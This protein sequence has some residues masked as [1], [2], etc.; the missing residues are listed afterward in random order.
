ME[1][2][3]TEWWTD[4]QKST[5]RDKRPKK[6][7]KWTVIKTSDQ[8]ATDAICSLSA[9]SDSQQ[10]QAQRCRRMIWCFL[11]R[12]RLCCEQSCELE[13][14]WDSSSWTAKNA[15]LAPPEITLKA[16]K[17]IEGFCAGTTPADALSSS[18]AVQTKRERLGSGY[19]FHTLTGTWQHRSACRTGLTPTPRRKWSCA[20]LC[21]EVRLSPISTGFRPDLHFL[22]LNT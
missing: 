15:P 16:P 22:R 12:S 9:G 21:C 2:K 20:E 19:H 8:T 5:G 14:K 4:L 10:T 1:N 3:S 17:M 6:R 18:R 13:G 7:Q 11:R